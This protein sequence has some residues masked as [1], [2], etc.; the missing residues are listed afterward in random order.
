VIAVQG[1]ETPISVTVPSMPDK[2]ELDP[3]L[4][5]LSEKTSVKKMN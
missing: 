1:T 3:D 5:V 4:F 2:V